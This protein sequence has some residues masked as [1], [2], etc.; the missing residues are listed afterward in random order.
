MRINQVGID[1][2]F[3]DLGGDSIVA[4]QIVVRAGEQ[5]ISITPNQLFFHQTIRQLAKA[6]ESG[7]ST[8]VASQ[9]EEVKP[10]SLVGQ[11]ANIIG[12]LSTLL[13]D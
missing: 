9:E 7:L 10:F 1:D 8:K 12:N 6:A 4:I 5:G 3:F 2:N 13:D 11:D